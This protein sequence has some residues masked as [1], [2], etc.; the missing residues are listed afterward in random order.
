MSLQV[1][2][3]AS[4]KIYIIIK[5]N[6]PILGIFANKRSVKYALLLKKGLIMSLQ[7]KAPASQKTTFL[8][9]KIVP[10]W[11]PNKM[12]RV[13]INKSVIHH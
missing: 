10:Y 4:Q 3:P 5:Q 8:L 6:I 12:Y 7:V 9:S 2:S 1:K 11:G 13:H